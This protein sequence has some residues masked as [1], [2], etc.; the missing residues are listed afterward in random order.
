MMEKSDKANTQASG[1]E[2]TLSSRVSQAVSFGANLAVMAGILFAFA[3]IRQANRI[4]RCQVAMTAIEPTRSTLFLQ[5]WRN[6]RQAYAID[7][8][9]SSAEQFLDDMHYV[10]NT[11]DNIS[12]LCLRG[13]ADEDLV[14]ASTHVALKDLLPI[15]NAMKLSQQSRTNLDR[16][17]ERF[18]RFSKGNKT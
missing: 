1:L 9:M 6:L 12:I 7:P 13:M 2:P 14:R 17:V 10:L 16:L 11:Y 4:Q 3:Q 18:D 5:A 8:T 15:M